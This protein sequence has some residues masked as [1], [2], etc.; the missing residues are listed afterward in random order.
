MSDKVKEY[1]GS[2][3]EAFRAVE[4]AGDKQFRWHN[5]KSKQIEIFAVKHEDPY[6]KSVSTYGGHHIAGQNNGPIQTSKMDTY[7]LKTQKT[8]GELNPIITNFAFRYDPDT[9]TRIISKLNPRQ[10]EYTP[11][12]PN[13][14]IEKG[15]ANP[16]NSDKPYT[17]RKTNNGS[18]N[19]TNSYGFNTPFYSGETIGNGGYNSTQWPQLKT[20]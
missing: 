15:Y 13:S 9:Q 6:A 19:V 1:T 3:G 20:F 4:K 2:F 8:S 7:L 17:P 5:P 16:W 11:G 12:V 14:W 18:V 10:Y